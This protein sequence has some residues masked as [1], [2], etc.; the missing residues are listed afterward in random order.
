MG[1][2][3]MALVLLLAVYST[4]AEQHSACDTLSIDHLGATIDQLR[5]IAETCEW[6][7]IATLFYNRAYLRELI[8][9]YDRINSMISADR[10]HQ[11]NF[12]AYRILIGL[13]ESFAAE[14]LSRGDADTVTRL[15]R[16]YDHYIEIAELRLKGYDLIANRMERE[17]R[18]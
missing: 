7:E 10:S 3:A 14:A 2:L 17:L 9:E 16:T 1:R 6:P 11:A 4:A 8:L 12:E 18:L 13:V 5:A 15:N